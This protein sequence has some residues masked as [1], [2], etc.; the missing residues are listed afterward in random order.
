MEN[1]LDPSIRSKT[2]SADEAQKWF[3]L[4]GLNINSW[5]RE[6]GFAPAL[7]YAVLQGRRKCLRG[8]SHQIAVALGLKSPN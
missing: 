4:N 1:K 5:A 3:R 6:Q 8:Q 7:V 2:L